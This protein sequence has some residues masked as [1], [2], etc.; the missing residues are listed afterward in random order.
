MA[1]FRNTRLWRSTLAEQ[2][3]PDQFADGRERLRNAFLRFRDKASR[4]AGEIQR[5]LPEFTVHDAS[6]LDA[7]WE[8]ADLISGSDLPFTP[9]EAFLFGGVA[10]IHDLG[11][12]A[13]AFPGGTRE[14]ED[15]P[16]W[17][18]MVTAVLKRKHG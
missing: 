11:M 5:D 3:E 18:D 14:L 16:S 8:M 15:D 7:L 12:A 6:H 2:N 13:A 17:G 1:D 10:L 9:M 4:I